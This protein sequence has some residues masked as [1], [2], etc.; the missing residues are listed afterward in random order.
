[1]KAEKSQMGQE[2]RSGSMKRLLAGEEGLRV[3]MPDKKQ[4]GRSMPQPAGRPTLRF[5]RLWVGIGDG[6][7]YRFQKGHTVRWRV[8]RRW[9][10]ELVS[11]RA[12]LVE[13]CHNRRNQDHRDKCQANQN[14]SH[15]TCLQAVWNRPTQ[16]PFQNRTGRGVHEEKPQFLEV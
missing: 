8:C 5:H 7:L 1:M 16:V 12:T 6:R 15:E 9:K 3:R 2:G 4:A 11:V 10:S 13:C 14:I